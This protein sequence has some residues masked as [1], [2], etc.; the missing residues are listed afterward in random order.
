VAVLLEEEAGVE[1]LGDLHG[2]G[3]YFGGLATPVRPGINPRATRQTKSRLKPA[4][5]FP[6]RGSRV[7]PA[8]RLI[9][10]PGI[11]G[12]TRDQLPGRVGA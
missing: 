11:H 3:L 8:F 5:G 6:V 2:A 10:S 1:V 9:R 4:P 7:H 12:R